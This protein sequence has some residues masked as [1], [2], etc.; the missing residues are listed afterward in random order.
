MVAICRGGSGF[1]ISGDLRYHWMRQKRLQGSHF[2]NDEQAYC[3]IRLVQDKI[4]DPCLSQTFTF[5]QTA[6]AHQLMFNNLHPSG[7]MSIL[8]NVKC[9]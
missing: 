8:V 9:G 3:F 5:D 4:V 2:S 1:Q 6:E 7:N